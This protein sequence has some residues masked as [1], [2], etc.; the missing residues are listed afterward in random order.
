MGRVPYNKLRKGPH[1]H[2]LIV[3]LTS[4]GFSDWKYP[5]DHPIPAKANKELTWSDLKSKLIEMEKNRVAGDPNLLAIAEKG[6]V[7]QSAAE[8]KMTNDLH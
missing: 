5:V 6:F 4:R 1:E 7:I 8:F 2:D 3:E